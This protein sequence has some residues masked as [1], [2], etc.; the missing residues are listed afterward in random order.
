MTNCK[1]GDIVVLRCKVISTGIMAYTKEAVLDLVPMCEVEQKPYT[2][3]KPW[4]VFGNDVMKEQ[5][6]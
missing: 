2:M 5:D 4:S 6:D 3:H 1:V